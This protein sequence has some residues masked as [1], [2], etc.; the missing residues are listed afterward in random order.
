MA[1]ELPQYLRA[2]QQFVCEV[3]G[4]KQLGCDCKFTT[5]SHTCSLVSTGIEQATA[6]VSPR[7][8]DGSNG[9]SGGAEAGLCEH[10]VCQC[11]DTLRHHVIFTFCHRAHHFLFL[12]VSVNE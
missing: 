7:L 4:L 11:S 3:D 5:L 12:L 1:P 10:W 6:P 9:G 8:R 2:Q